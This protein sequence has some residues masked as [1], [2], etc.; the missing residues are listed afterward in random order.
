MKKLCV[1]ILFVVFGSCYSQ[2]IQKHLM[3]AFTS[4]DSSDYY[5]KIAK[6]NIKSKADE[7]QYY[8]CK[9]ARCTD[10]SETDSAIIYGKK[11]I[12]M[13]KEL[14]DYQTLC[15]VYSNIIK[16]YRKQGEYDTATSY[17]LEGLT[18]AEKL[19]YGYWLVH[20]NSYLSL[21]YHDFESYEKGIYYG[22]KSL[23]YALKS[24]KKSTSEIV[25]AL[26][27]I[28]INYDDWNK[29]DSALYY[30]KK[31]IDYVKG[32][33]TLT[34][35]STYNNIGNTLLK[36]KKYKEAEKW[37]LRA[38]KLTNLEAI[39]ETSSVNYYQLAT[40]YTNLATIAF[41]LNDYSKAEKL[42]EKAF[43]YSK[44]SK[45]AEKLRDYYYQKSKFE[46]KRN[47]LQ[48]TVEEQE[49]YIKLR[50]S[51]FAIE[52]EKTFSELEAKYQNE[53]KEKELLRSK[54]EIIQNENEIKRK[55][56][57]FLILSLIVVGL[58]I[59]SYLIYRQQKLK[60]KQQEQEFE[61]KSAIS[62]IE[63]QNELQEQR[64]QISRDLHDNIGSQLTF[65][66]SSVDNIKY[67]FDITNEK[68]DNKLSGI[69][70]FAKSTIIELRDTIWAMNKSE[71]TFEDLQIRIHNFIEKAK[72]AKTDVNFNF[73]VDNQLKE[74]KFSSVEGM[75]IYRT[76]QEA[77]N[78]S[79]KYANSKSISIAIQPNNDAIEILISDDGKGFKIDEVS[80]G[81]GIVNMKKRISDVNGIFELQSNEN[82]GTKI[83]IT[84]P[85]K[86]KKV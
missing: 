82:E 11:A 18:L 79:M 51:V 77:I 72:I 43:L 14:K 65:I 26:N 38:L 47:N 52:R 33:D 16:V 54:N 24:K 56:T 23:D 3:K 35:S 57:Q 83:K 21:N 1:F 49:N 63:T 7:S 2:D 4:Q 80:L 6:R 59:I 34:L 81:N 68:L 60:N 25:T 40:N 53:K 46:K 75:N 78:N 71:I 84:I 76:I 86:C 17:A 19:K 28:A 48:K 36:Q 45:N 61:L 69:S 70:D 30:H 8:F 32:K 12:K 27:V 31:V 29:P 55:N 85:K 58:L 42:F 74:C 10:Y 15:S 66:I 22:K 9:N 5:F 20:Y 37:I 50:D 13:L 64:L 67:A 39:N 41:E 62:R 73:T 44:E